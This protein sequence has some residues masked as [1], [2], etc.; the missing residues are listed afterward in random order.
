MAL[1]TRNRSTWRRETSI[2]SWQTAGRII[3]GLRDLG[4]ANLA[5]LDHNIAG[6]GSNPPAQAGLATRLSAATPTPGRDRRAGELRV[7]KCGAVLP[8]RQRPTLNG[9]AAMVPM[10]S[11]PHFLPRRLPLP[12]PAAYAARRDEGL[13]AA[14]V[15]NSDASQILGSCR[16]MC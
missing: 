2:R 7:K 15:V 5:D 9:S 11:V 14:A 12:D 3:A 16:R 1:D 4:A 8:L 10:S 6:T 13:R